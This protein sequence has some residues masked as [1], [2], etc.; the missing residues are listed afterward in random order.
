MGGDR[1]NGF[2]RF[3][4]DATH[5]APVVDLS[6][7]VHDGLP[8]NWVFQ[9]FETS[10]HRFWVATV[11]GLVESTGDARGRR[12]HS[13]GRRNGLT[14]RIINRLQEDLAGNLW[15]GTN[16][17]GAMKVTRDGLTTY[18]EQ[19]GIEIVNAVFED[20]AGEVCFRGS[21]L[22]P[23]RTSVSSEGRRTGRRPHDFLHT[24]RLLRWPAVRLVHARCRRDIGW[25]QEQTT[26]QART[27]EWWLGTGEG[28]YRFPAVD[29]FAQ[30]RTARP[31]AVYTMRDGL[32]VLQVFRLF[33]DSGGNV[34][35]STTSPTSVGL[36]RW[37]HASQTVRDLSHLPG[38]SSF[39]DDL[40]RAFGEDH[41]GH[42]WIGFSSAVARY[43]EGGFTFF[44]AK[45]GVPPGAIG[46]IFVDHAGRLWLASAVA[47]SVA[48][49]TPAR[50]GPRSGPT[51]PRKA[52]RA[53]AP[54]SSPRTVT[55]ISMS[56]VDEDST[57]SIR[58]PAASS[59]S[60]RPT[61]SRP[62][63]FTPRFATTRACSGSA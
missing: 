44:T 14:D 47:D 37:D 27:G 4:A 7:T 42:V 22:G 30:L 52:C 38:L 50:I 35:I 16:S 33:E 17:A 25:V 36:A 1:Y 24:A 18:G 54:A 48:S 55:A 62:V 46:D 20:R 63:C 34:W 59:I 61:A 23:A 41:S 12:L 39:K 21:V 40:P 10:A 60:R 19:D 8:T 3:T 9:L 2:F 29:H 45:D 26:L 28:L 11:Q 43:Q 6:V 13:Y 53:T 57:G 56:A 49:T 15:L 58:R 32:A 31:R 5:A 51:R